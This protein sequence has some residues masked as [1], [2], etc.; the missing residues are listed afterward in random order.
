MS[1]YE[2]EGCT[3]TIVFAWTELNGDR[4]IQAGN[5]GDSSAIICRKGSF[6]PLTFDHK[7]KD[8]EQEHK[9]LR[10]MGIE[11]HEHQS[12][13]HGLAICRTLGDHCLKK[14][15]EKTGIIADPYVS[16]V[17]QIE[18]GDILVVASDGLWDVL[19]FQRASEMVKDLANTTEMVRK[20]MNVALGHPECKDNVT[21][22]CSIMA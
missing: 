16:E 1:Q 8:N 21:I 13:L 11:M 22:I 10:D 15:N 18:S 3:S 12:R 2:Y 20:L 14:S 4:F 17:V 9:R 5:V 19:T 6:I 7:V